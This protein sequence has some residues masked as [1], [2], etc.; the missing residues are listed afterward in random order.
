MRL[1][2]QRGVLLALVML[3]AC[4]CTGGGGQPTATLPPT[5]AL[6]PSRPTATPTPIE[7]TPT[8]TL[9]PSAADVARTAAAA[10]P[11]LDATAQARAAQGEIALAAVRAAGDASKGAYSLATLTGVRAGR[12]ID[13]CGRAQSGMVL[14]SVLQQTTVTEVL[15]DGDE[16]R[17]CGSYNLYDE[18]PDVYLALDPVAA[19][20]TAIAIDRAARS[21][22]VE[23]DSIVVESVRPVAWTAETGAC[24]AEDAVTGLSGSAAGYR[25]V[26]LAGDEQFVYH[27]D[28]DR[29]IPCSADSN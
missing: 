2:A 1:M 14:A 10:V 3:L 28:F 19:D 16:A 5:Q 27:T 17:I 26:L 29:L 24:E 18:R 25:I 11:T 20:L 23:A 15:V 6:N 12:E 8:L 21:A 13:G 7:A 9:P 4:A 22:E